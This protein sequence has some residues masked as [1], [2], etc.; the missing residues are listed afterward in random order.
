MVIPFKCFYVSKYFLTL[1][2]QTFL[3]NTELI[4]KRI[5]L[6]HTEKSS[7]H[8]MESKTIEFYS[9]L[10]YKGNFFFNYSAIFSKKIQMFRNW[11]F[12]SFHSSTFF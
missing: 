12:C 5:S 10:R 9:R 4:L 3:W 7:I 8:F 1:C 2:D 11:A 6:N